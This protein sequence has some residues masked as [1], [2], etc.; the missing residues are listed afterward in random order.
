[1]V[2]DARTGKVGLFRSGR[3]L[4]EAEDLSTAARSEVRATFRW[5]NANL[6]VPRR[7]PKNAICWFRG[8]ARESLDR[9]RTLIEIYRLAGHPVWMQATLNPGRVVYRDEHQVAAVPYPDRRT[10]ANVV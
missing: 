5:F 8:D 4:D 10:T 3:I 2:E 6:A 9:L 1:V 7:L